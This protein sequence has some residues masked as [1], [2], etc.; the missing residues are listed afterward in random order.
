MK[1]VNSNTVTSLIAVMSMNVLFFL[2]LTLPILVNFKFEKLKPGIGG[3]PYEKSFLTP[4]FNLL[5]MSSGKCLYDREA[6]FVE[7]ECQF[8]NLVRVV[9]VSD[10]GQCTGQDTEGRVD[11]G[12]RNTL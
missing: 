11:Q 12:L 2:I 3:K 9:V 5:L 6:Y 1:K 10:N 7:S 4:H 8:I